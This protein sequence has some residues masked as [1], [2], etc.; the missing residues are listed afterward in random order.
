MKSWQ[1]L[2][3]FA[4]ATDKFSVSATDSLVYMVKSS[5]LSLKFL[6]TR[7]SDYIHIITVYG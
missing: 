2:N 5:N 6:K 1:K 7:I 4:E 3:K